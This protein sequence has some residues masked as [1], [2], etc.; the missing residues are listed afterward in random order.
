MVKRYYDDFEVGDK[1]ES[2]VGRTVSEPD[3]YT[4]AGL[5]GSYNELHTNREAMQDSEFGGRIAQG[6]LL[7]VL[8]SGFAKRV[9]WE[10]DAIALYGIDN[11][12]FTA[13]V[14][15]DDTL[16]MESEVT[17]KRPKDDDRGVVTFERRLYKSDGTL[18]TTAE[19]SIL[20]PRTDH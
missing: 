17:E 6:P 12:R 5:V 10:P 14:L 13:P 7:L 8:M 16:H 11:V 3:L 20:V 2:S 18:T 9:P 15:I 4:T 19:Y 1:A